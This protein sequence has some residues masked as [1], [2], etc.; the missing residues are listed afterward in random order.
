ME[1]N[2]GTT[3]ASLKSLIIRIDIE[4]YNVSRVT[5]LSEPSQ[6]DIRKSNA[7]NSDNLQLP[8]QR[9]GYVG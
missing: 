4:L 1:D 9:L 5:V 8:Y 6:V 7:F 2:P 3:S